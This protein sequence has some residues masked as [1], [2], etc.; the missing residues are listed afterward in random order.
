VTEEYAP[1]YRAFREKFCDLDD[2]SASRR[3]VDRMLGLA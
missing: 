2:G 1:A 3:V